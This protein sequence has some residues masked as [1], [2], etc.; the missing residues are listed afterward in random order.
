MA[1]EPPPPGRA[2]TLVLERAYREAPDSEQLLNALT[3]CYT[4]QRRAEDALKLWEQAI[5]RASGGT[6]VTLM[7]RYAEMLLQ[8]G[9]LAEHVKVQMRIVEMETEVKRRREAFK[10][11]LDRLLW[12][13]ESGGELPEEVLKSRLKLVQDSLTALT[14]KHPFDGF[15]HE[16]LAGL[17]ERTGDASR[18]FAAMKQ[19][20]Y[21]APDTPFS[22]DQ[23]REAALKA[24]DLKAA[25]Y[26]QKQVAASAEYFEDQQDGAEGQPVPER[27]VL[28]VLH[29]FLPSLLSKVARTIS[30]IPPT[31]PITWLASSGISTT[32]LL[33]ADA[34][35]PRA[36]TYFCATK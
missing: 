13:G 2:A 3:Q 34:S 7:Q 12:A 28:Q 35:L 32:L 20:Y 15:Y 4:L 36:S 26:F 24:G 17:H 6:A 30:P 1:T 27:Q 31:A 25:I 9:K 29:H 16:A 22:L 8:R 14:K 11:F 21:T 19:A 18:A 5:E 10:R 33:L 23:L